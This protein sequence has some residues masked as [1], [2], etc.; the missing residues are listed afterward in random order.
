MDIIDSLKSWNN[1]EELCEDTE[2]IICRRL[3]YNAKL[4][5]FPKNYR[6]LE[7]FI[8]ASSTKIRNRMDEHMKIKKKLNL[9]ICGLTTKSVINYIKDQQL[10]S[11]RL[12]HTNRKSSILKDFK[13]SNSDI[14]TEQLA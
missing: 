4:E 9:G 11:L 12:S 5:N 7:N 14:F 1:G 8:D 10:Y 13:E 3:N 6:V 2:F